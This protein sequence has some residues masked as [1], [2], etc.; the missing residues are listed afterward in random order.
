MK[1]ATKHLITHILTQ[2]DYVALGNI[3]C[4][5]RGDAFWKNRKRPCQ[6]LGTRIAS[7]LRQ[8]LA[9]NGRS[10]YVGAGVAELPMLIMETTE[11]HRSIAAHNLRKDEVVILNKTCAEQPFTFLATNALHAQGRFDHLWLVSVLNDPECYPETSALS[12]G[13]ATPFTFNPDIFKKEQRLL[14]RLVHLCLSTLTMP[15]LV[16]TSVEEIPWITAWCLENDV[17]FHIENKTY[18]T[19]IVGDPL[20]FIHLGKRLKRAYQTKTRNL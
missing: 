19:A 10:L 11:L 2:L 15:G 17:S 14:R 6:Q 12:Y 13:R 18:P 1:L 7:S 3:Y 20:C 4:D 9:P 8:R 5:D 16:T